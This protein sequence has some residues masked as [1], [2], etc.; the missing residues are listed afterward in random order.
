M[1]SVALASAMGACVASGRPTRSGTAEPASNGLRP[2]HSGTNVKNFGARGDGVTD[3]T[4]AIQRALDS[5]SHVFFPA[6]TYVLRTRAEGYALFL[7]E[8]S[9]L[10][11]EGAGATLRMS[12]GEPCTGRRRQML[13][14]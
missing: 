2:P 12:D 8:K 10:V 7:R 13:M 5:E 1:A 6:G 11:M 4:D 3:D 9:S 14:L